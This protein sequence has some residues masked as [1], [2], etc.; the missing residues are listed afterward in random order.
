MPQVPLQSDI[1]AALSAALSAT[2][3]CW[4]SATAVPGVSVD[5]SDDIQ[6]ACCRKIG[7]KI[8]M[9]LRCPIV[10]LATMKHYNAQCKSITTMFVVKKVYVHILLT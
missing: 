3:D 2:E 1:P 7:S 8:N 10:E 9:Q 5:V 6:R 4:S